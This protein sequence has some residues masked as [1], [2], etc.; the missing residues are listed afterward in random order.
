[1]RLRRSRLRSHA[2]QHISRGESPQTPHREPALEPTRT[3]QHAATTGGAVSRSSSWRR[4]PCKA[5]QPDGLA[6]RIAGGGSQS[7]PQYG[8][9]SESSALEWSTVAH[10]VSLVQPD[11]A[12]V[13]S[14]RR[15]APREL[16]ETRD[17]WTDWPVAWQCD[18]GDAGPSLCGVVVTVP[19]GDRPVCGVGVRTQTRAAVRLSQ[20]GVAVA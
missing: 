18:V 3:D 12:R 2:L 9:T 7:S 20:T 15:S 5:P 6:P 19:A 11:N 10:S 17:A 4:T 8:Q 13:A 14:P 1:L 16:G